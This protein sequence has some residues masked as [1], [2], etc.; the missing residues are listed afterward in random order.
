MLVARWGTSWVLFDLGAACANKF[1]LGELVALSSFVAAHLLRIAAIRNRGLV[2]WLL[3]LRRAIQ[4]VPQVTVMSIERS[5]TRILT[6]SGHPPAIESVLRGQVLR[7]L[8]LIVLACLSGCVPS[9]AQGVVRT[10]AQFAHTAWGPKDGA[11]SVV[12]VLAQS[13]DGYLWL[14]GP[15]G[16]YRF[17]GVVFESYQPQSGGPFPARR[18][19]SLFALPN[20]DLWIGFPTGG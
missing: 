20:G 11:P 15:N 7:T 18:V 3:F 1:H 14:G 16:L 8:M 4:S 2:L 9:E 13:A 5:L 17:D 6:I 10:V 19:S 12:D